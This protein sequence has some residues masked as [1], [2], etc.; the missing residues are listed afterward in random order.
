MMAK[1]MLIKMGL[2]VAIMFLMLLAGVLFISVMADSSNEINN[3]YAEE[4]QGG[5]PSVE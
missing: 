3:S 5:C 1:D 2:A 4:Q